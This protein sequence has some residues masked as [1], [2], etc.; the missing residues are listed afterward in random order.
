MA[1]EKSAQEMNGELL[2][3]VRVW[4]MER[5]EKGGVERNDAERERAITS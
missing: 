5:K 4:R 2:W 3:G 1:Q